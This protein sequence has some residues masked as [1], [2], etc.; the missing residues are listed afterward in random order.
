ME[1]VTP[2]ISVFIQLQGIVDIDAEIKKL[3]NMLTGVKKSYKV[4]EERMASPMYQN[5]PV[6][7]Q[8]VDKQKLEELKTKIS[9]GEKALAGFQ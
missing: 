3:Q 8:E 5:V 7:K 9:M 2:S 4:L 6:E 1:I